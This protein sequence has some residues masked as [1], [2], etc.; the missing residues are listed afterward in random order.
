MDNYVRIRKPT[1]IGEIMYKLH[2]IKPT[3][4]EAENSPLRSKDGA[5]NTTESVDYTKK[6]TF[7]RYV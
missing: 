1:I 7:Q 2:V 4:I 6:P 3:Q 5:D